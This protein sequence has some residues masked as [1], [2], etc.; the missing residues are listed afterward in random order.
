MLAGASAGTADNSQLL[1][2]IDSSQFLRS[3]VEDTS[4]ADLGALQGIN[5]GYA[6]TSG[7]GTTWGGNIW[8]MSKLGTSGNAGTGFNPVTGHNGLVW[9]RDGN[10]NRHTTIREGVHQYAS[11]TLINAF[12]T[13]GIYTKGQILAVGNITAYYSDERLKD[14]HSELDTKVALQAVCSWSKVRYTA[15]SLA[16]QLAGYDTEKMEIG[17]LAGQISETYPEL[18]PLAAFDDDGGVSKS[19]EDYKTLDYERVV[20]VQ[21]AAIEELANE[22][23]EL[24]SRLERLESIVLS[25]Q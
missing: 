24:R 5:G 9:L 3:D 2:G 13:G 8:S 11:G 18:T 16:N 10:I 17:L 25:L 19:G 21:A 14:V 4:Y 7:S 23:E 12:G 6:T 1:D 15:N 20:A 22:N